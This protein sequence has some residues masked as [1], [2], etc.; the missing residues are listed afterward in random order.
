VELVEGEI[1]VM[2]PIGERH[3]A[4]VDRAATL[5]IRRAGDAANVRVQGPTRLSDRS[6]PEPDVLLLRPRGDFYAAG[7]P[8]PEDVLLLVE[9][10]DSSLRYDREIKVALYA[11]RGIREVWLLDL[12]GARLEV[13]RGPGSDGYRT[14]QRLQRG[15]RIVPEALPDL[16]VAVDE[17][18]G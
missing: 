4:A 1:V 8:G 16:E 18:L 6:E 17:L 9:V 10:A 5:F 11:R 3:A 12:A 14:T 13:Y 2:S 15:E 7:H